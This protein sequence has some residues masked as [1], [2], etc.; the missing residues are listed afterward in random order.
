MVKASN[1]PG[2][3]RKANGD[4]TFR[5]YWSARSDLVKRGYR[6]SS[7]RL[8]YPDTTDGEMQCAA[9]CR[10][11]WAEMLA[12][13]AGGGSLPARG[14]DGTIGSLCN[15]FQTHD[16]SPY[17]KAKWNSQRLYDQQSRSFAIRSARGRSGLSSARTTPV[18]TRNGR[19]RR[20]KA[21]RDG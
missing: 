11:L 16:A 13:E 9:R 4:G 1:A 17:L 20:Q 21:S 8:H 6:P 15:V 14:Y 12:W 5:Y 3:K 18:G 7:V 2:L 19:S 10:I